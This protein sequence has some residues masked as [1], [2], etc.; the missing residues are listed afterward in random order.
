M[1]KSV[2][3]AV[4]IVLLA[5]S[6]V[7][8]TTIPNADFCTNALGDETC[9]ERYPD[10]SRPYC[11]VAECLD[12]FYGCFPYVPAEECASPCGAENPD[13]GVN[14][15]TTV[16]GTETG[17][18]SSSE[19][20]SGSGSESSGSTTGPMPCTSDDECTD[21]DAPFCGTSGECGGC[22]GTKDPDGACGGV[23]PLLPLCVGGACVACTAENP[24][25]CEEQ[26]LL[27]DG[28]T[29]ACVPC[30]E[31]GQCGSGACELAVGIC[32]PPG[33]V[34][35]VD[36]DGGQD[37]MTVAAAVAS[38]GA[39]MHGVIVVHENDGDLPY[40]AAGGL[41]VDGG[42]TIA[43]LAAP[44]EAPILV[45]TGAG[46]PSL[47]VAGA[48]TVLYVD[49]LEVTDADGE[50][51]RVNDALAWVDRSRIVQN[52]GGGVLAENGAEL[53]LRNCFVG[54]LGDVVGVEVNGA[55]ASVLYSTVTASTFGSTPALGCTMPVTVDIRNSIIVSQGGTPPD[56]LACA[57]VDVSNTATEADVGAFNIGWFNG[58]NAGDFSLSASGAMMFADVAQWSTGDPLTDI[59]GDSR[60]AVDGTPDYAGADVP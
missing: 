11:V 12:D 39:G 5:T 52:S 50:G 36:G 58:F 14:T 16:S 33:D 17:S 47:R 24:T 53:T 26:L 41:L 44:G 15:S 13:C 3:T 43:L 30:T 28:G 20:G 2:I 54:G 49:G 27:C 9:A 4:T 18:G 45:G 1:S 48:D 38:I 8:R 31:H 10:G 40:L 57:S 56:E 6:C 7:E 46:N 59:D 55:S 22:D 23:D 51:L 25:A 37:F 34:V 35:H 21:P 42:K 60:P 19:S 29:N 32:F